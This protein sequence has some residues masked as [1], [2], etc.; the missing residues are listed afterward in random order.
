MKQSVRN[1]FRNVTPLGAMSCLARMRGANP[2]SGPVVGVNLPRRYIL[3][4][5]ARDPHL[6]DA[7]ECN[8]SVSV[9]STV[10]A[11]HKSFSGKQFQE[12]ISMGTCRASHPLI[13][14]RAR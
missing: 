12:N 11:S 1:K 2:P 8:Q 10:F 6:M 7:H 4:K 3:G 14:L 9:F 13:Y 5:A